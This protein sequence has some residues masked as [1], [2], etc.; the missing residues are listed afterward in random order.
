MPAFEV[1]NNS[2]SLEFDHLQPLQNTQSIA[3]IYNGH[4]VRI[5]RYLHA[6]FILFDFLLVLFLH[7]IWKDIP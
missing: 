3:Y 4:R 7:R 1:I 6:P 5:L 2:T